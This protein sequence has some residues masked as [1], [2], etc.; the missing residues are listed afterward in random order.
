MK[1]NERWCTAAT[2]VCRT[3]RIMRISNNQRAIITLRSAASSDDTILLNVGKIRICVCHKTI[4]YI[5]IS[6]L[7]M[8]IIYKS[9]L[10][11]ISMNHNYKQDVNYCKFLIYKVPILRLE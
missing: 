4:I 5:G 3:C 8:I 2:A 10:S 1:V 7:I 6:I 11:T 9:Q